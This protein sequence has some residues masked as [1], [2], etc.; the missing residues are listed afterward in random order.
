VRCL[1]RILEGMERREEAVIALRFEPQT[2]GSGRKNTVEEADTLL[3]YYHVTA[4]ELKR[5]EATEAAG[6]RL[7]QVLSI[8]NGLSRAHYHREAKRELE[9]LEGEVAQK[10]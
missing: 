5:L 1:A 2:L 3:L 4:M 9:K 10:N 8:E 6:A 7:R